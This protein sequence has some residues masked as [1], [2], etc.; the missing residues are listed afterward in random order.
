VIRVAVVGLGMAVTPHARSLIDLAARAQVAYAF[1]PSVERRKAF[2]AKFPFP[3]CADLETILQ[4]RSV[5]AV[6]G[7]REPRVNGEEA[8]KVHRLIDALLQIPRSGG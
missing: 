1:S 7:D 2:A 3:Q 6:E 4:D 5:A 8:L